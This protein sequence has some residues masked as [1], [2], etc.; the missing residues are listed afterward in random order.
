MNELIGVAYCD[1]DIY[2]YKYF[3]VDELYD[4]LQFARI[5]SIG[6]NNISYVWRCHG[7]YSNNDFIES[8]SVHIATYINGLLQ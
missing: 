7:T 8:N 1:N 3:C 6:F 5:A 4:A 2:V